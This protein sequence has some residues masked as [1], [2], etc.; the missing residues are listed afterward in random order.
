MQ[1]GGDTTNGD[2]DYAEPK[3]QR[4]GRCWYETTFEDDA[5]GEAVVGEP[6]VVAAGVKDGDQVGKLLVAELPRPPEL[7][8]AGTKRTPSVLELL[9]RNGVKGAPIVS[10]S[11][12]A[13]GIAGAKE[14]GH[15]ELEAGVEGFDVGPSVLLLVF[16][17]L[18]M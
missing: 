4:A 8:C 16:R 11:C 14:V 12:S 18:T 15:G 7:H 5:S 1:A 9:R 3:S 10:S 2:G 13:V 6:L 17:L